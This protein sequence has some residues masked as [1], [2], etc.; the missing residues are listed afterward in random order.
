[1]K[2]AKRLPLHATF[3]AIAAASIAQHAHAQSQAT[4]TLLQG[5][6]EI[7]LLLKVL[8][9]LLSVFSIIA[10]AVYAYRGQ[11]PWGWITSLAFSAALLYLAPYVLEHA[12]D[13]N[14]IATAAAPNNSQANVQAQA[15]LPGTQTPGQPNIP[16][17]P[18]T[19]QERMSDAIRDWCF[20]NVSQDHQALTQ[21]T[22]QPWFHDTDN[23]LITLPQ[24]LL[25]SVCSMLRLCATPPTIPFQG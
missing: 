4:Q 13:Y 14:P 9:I 7:Y 18:S 21:C 8:L 15:P 17:Q 23:D 3:P 19:Y 6:T 24:A 16:A 1:M 22:E 10:I 12:I 5:L 11:I 20:D 2:P 25:T